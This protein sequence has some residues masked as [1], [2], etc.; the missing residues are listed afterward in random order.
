MGGPW[1]WTLVREE[2]RLRSPP[3]F[4]APGPLGPGPETQRADWAAGVPNHSTLRS[5]FPR[6]D[7]SDTCSTTRPFA[8][9]SP[10][11]WARDVCEGSPAGHTWS[12][13]DSS[14]PVTRD[15]D[16]AGRPR[17]ARPRD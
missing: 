15:R 3:A 8:W 11:V 2:P 10:A 14:L 1:G 13:A 9:A 6:P 5:L 17:N 4:P 16:A 7:T 12:M